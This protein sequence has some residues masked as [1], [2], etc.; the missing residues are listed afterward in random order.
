MRLRE[1]AGQD[2]RRAPA[3]SSLASVVM[4]LCH[5][6]GFQALR[7]LWVCGRGAPDHQLWPR[8]RGKE[9]L[10]AV[11]VNFFQI[12]SPFYAELLN[13]LPAELLWEEHPANREEGEKR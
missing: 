6:G 8:R 3:G 10:Q 4:G 5:V 7:S 2:L 9:L 13:Q 1:T 12:K 11:P